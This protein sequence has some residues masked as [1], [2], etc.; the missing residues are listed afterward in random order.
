MK[1][2]FPEDSYHTPDEAPRYFFDKIALGSRYYFH[3]KF[4]RQV[5]ASKKLADA[6]KFDRAQWALASY[7]IFKIIEGC[8]GRFHLTGLNNLIECPKPVVFVSNHMSTLETMVFPSIIAPRMKASFVIKESLSMHPLIGSIMIARKPIVVKRVN[9]REDLQAVMS[10]GLEMLEKGRSVIIF[11][12]S[13]RTTKFIPEEFNTL[14]IKLAKRGNVP[15]LPIAIK[16]DFWENGK[17]LKD[18]GAIK[19]QEHIHMAFGKAMEI[20]GNGKEEHKLTIDFIATHLQK[21]GTH[22]G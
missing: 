19:R 10:Q 3:Y 18:L 12:Q 6:G 2:Y 21:W 17:Y 1:V 8:G 13:T 5:L 11:P 15:V 16:T 22:I 4:I 7:N 9:P 20:T 14:G